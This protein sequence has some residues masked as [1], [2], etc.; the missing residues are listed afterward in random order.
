MKIISKSP[1]LLVLIS[2]I[3]LFDLSA[4]SSIPT[5]VLEGLSYR[6]VGPSRGGR[7]TAITGIPNQPFTFFMGSTGGGVWKTDD[8]GNNWS[9]ISDG[10]I[11][12][13]G[14]GAIT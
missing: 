10:Q 7:A 1:L 9:N 12:A 6:S 3:I 14:I 11:K 2:T 8:A 5:E 13:G 4:Q